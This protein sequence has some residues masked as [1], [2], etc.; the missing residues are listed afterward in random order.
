LNFTNSQ[1]LVGIR[2]FMVNFDGSGF[3]KIVK[4]NYSDVNFYQNMF[5]QEVIN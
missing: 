3:T 4:M 1:S 2:G 5:Q